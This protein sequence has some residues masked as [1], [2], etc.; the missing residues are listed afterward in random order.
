M[1]ITPLDIQEK[2][3]ERS[4][5]G[6]DMEDVDDFLDE[7]AG[8][9]EKLLRKNEE[10]KEE[11]NRLLEKNKNYHK[12]EET[13]HSAIV[14]A[15]ETAEEV[16][17]NAKRESDLIRREAEREAKQII[18]DA[19]FRASRIMS[20]HEELIKQAQIFKMRFRSFIEAQLVS[21][22]NED[23]LRD[24]PELEEKEEEVLE[25]EP[26]PLNSEN[27]DA[28]MG[29]EKEKEDDFG[30]RYDLDPDDYPETDKDPDF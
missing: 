4:F 20:E 8:D 19:R 11:I 18:E 15:Q 12:M 3:F 24:A 1:P 10:L 14:V 30:I 22:E 17:Q 9:L 29:T 21:L 7:V 6:Y 25:F 13:L 2:E 28:G 26:G 5:R 23:W 16:K 27:V